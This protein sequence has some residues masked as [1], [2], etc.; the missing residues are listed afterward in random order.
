[1]AVGPIQFS[2]S[3]NP[4][5]ALN[6]RLS[7]MGRAEIV[8]ELKSTPALVSGGHYHDITYI[9]RNGERRTYAVLQG[10]MDR[11][12]D[13]VA[14]FLAHISD[15]ERA[16]KEH[17]EYQQWR[18]YLVDHAAMTA[19]SELGENKFPRA[20]ER[21]FLDFR[22]VARSQESYQTF[23]CSDSHVGVIKKILDAYLTHH[24]PGLSSI[25]CDLFATRE[26][27]HAM[28]QLS[29]PMPDW[30]K[31]RTIRIPLTQD[32]PWFTAAQQARDTLREWIDTAA[33]KNSETTAGNDYIVSI[34]DINY[35]KARVEYREGIEALPSRFG[36][37]GTYKAGAKVSGIP[38]TGEP[39]D[40][41]L[42][43]YKGDIVV[44]RNCT[45]V[46]DG[47]VQCERIETNGKSAL[48]PSEPTLQKVAAN[49]RIPKG[50]MVSSD[51]EVVGKAAPARGMAYL[52]GVPVG[53]MTN[54]EYDDT[55]VRL[56]ADGEGR[57]TTTA[58][59]VREAIDRSAISVPTEKEIERRMLENVMR[60]VPRFAPSPTS[61]AIIRSVAASTH[62]TYRAI[63]QVAEGARLQHEASRVQFDNLTSQPL[64]AENLQAVIDLVRG[65]VGTPINAAY[66][67]SG[68]ITG[69][70]SDKDGNFVV[71]L[72]AQLRQPPT[73][74]NIPLD[75][76]PA[77][78]DD[79][80]VKNTAQKFEELPAISIEILNEHFRLSGIQATLKSLKSHPRLH[81][82]GYDH[83]AYYIGRNGEEYAFDWF[84]GPSEP[85]EG[86]GR[87]FIECLIAR[88]EIA[89]RDDVAKETA[90][91]PGIYDPNAPVTPNPPVPLRQRAT[92]E[93]IEVAYRTAA[94]KLP[95]LVRK[96]LVK[97][98][99]TKGGKRPS[100]A[101]L[102]LAEDMLSGDE[103]SLIVAGILS[104]AL[105][106]SP[107]FIKSKMPW[108]D[109][110][111][112]ATA[113]RLDVETRIACAVADM[114]GMYL[115]GALAALKEAFG[116]SQQL[117]LAEGGKSDE[118][119]LFNGVPKVE[120][121]RV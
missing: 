85:S 75:F 105:S 61:E 56:N 49:Q 68:K 104:L 100:Q 96:Q 111:R 35:L 17:E 69:V 84:Q 120:M 38:R 42:K 27:G 108:L 78:G 39:F 44:L 31:C 29:A 99:A 91:M 48:M 119:A 63:A 81:G 37:T 59:Q 24:L 23:T 82:G 26:N 18:Q 109:L 28:V 9:A 53:V 115:D 65:Q 77:I 15:A 90:S 66:G 12:N 1:M 87:K 47:E 45:W 52:N 20:R 74:V 36:F 21:A 102:S 55:T 67:Q 51:G 32:M 2:V 16:A 5:D 64:T 79:E 71:S 22:T 97:R 72:E 57:V 25:K 50:A 8:T 11:T 114:L 93:A 41:A 89:R 62:D 43:Y 86:F 118:S 13:L 10:P 107:E 19:G 112:L 121:V 98:M 30:R 95:D 54:I 40:I 34:W 73:S 110:N 58:Q 101:R 6:A 33:Q 106:A 70:A 94:I 80:R 3:T 4:I 7:A 92:A 116:G 83:R 88:G 14:N 113:L 103:G 46:A 60:D 76:A 117:L